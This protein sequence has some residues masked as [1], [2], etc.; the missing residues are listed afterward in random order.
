[1]RRVEKRIGPGDEG[2]SVRDVLRNDL[3]FSDGRISRL[4][5]LPDGILLDGE[6]AYVTAR[7]REGQLLSARAEDGFA[8]AAEPVPVFLPVLYE[9]EDYVVIDKPAGIAVHATGRGAGETTLENAMA[10]LLG[11]GC[12]AHPVSRLDRGTTGAML[13][14]KSGW[15]HELA[16]RS[17]REVT[18]PRLTLTSAGIAPS[19]RFERI[20]SRVGRWKNC[21][22]FMWPRSRVMYSGAPPRAY[23][24]SS[25][26]RVPGMVHGG[27]WGVYICSTQRPGS[28]FSRA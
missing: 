22:P 1:M 16:R 19:A 26:A 27:M 14:A 25:S 24:R 17:Q 6:K 7:V 3:S 12:G 5:R 21:W 28:P 4:K 13:W 20:A 10:A 18:T 2:R 9:D 8:Q 15:A 11:P 23:T